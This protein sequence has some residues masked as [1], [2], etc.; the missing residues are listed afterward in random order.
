MN[1]K[2]SCTGCQH[3]KKKTHTHKKKTNRNEYQYTC[4]NLNVE[5][6]ECLCTGLSTRFAGLQGGSYSV[7]FVRGV[8]LTPAEIGFSD[9][10]NST[11]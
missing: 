7:Y 8:L 10:V 1:T 3:L 2:E 6:D 4:L 11:G 5:K 9:V